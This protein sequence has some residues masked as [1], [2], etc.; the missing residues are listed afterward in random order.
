MLPNRKVLMK[1]L[2][3]KFKEKTPKENNSK[4]NL[5]ILEIWKS[6]IILKLKD[7][8]SKHRMINDKMTS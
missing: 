1:N 2:K 8:Q 5:H 4:Q 7:Y 6:K 3:T